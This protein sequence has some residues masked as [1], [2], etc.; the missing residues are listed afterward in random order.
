MS[1]T[2][3]YTEPPSGPLI[4]DHCVSP[5]EKHEVHKYVKFIIGVQRT[6][7]HEECFQIVRSAINKFNT[8]I[9]QGD[10]LN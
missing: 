10:R 8:V 4:C 9:I 6:N 7:F 2:L 1:L 3:Q 5:I